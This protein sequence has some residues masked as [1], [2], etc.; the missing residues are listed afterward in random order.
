MQLILLHM[1]VRLKHT[2]QIICLVLFLLYAWPNLTFNIPNN[3]PL[4]LKDSEKK[5]CFRDS[6][7]FFNISHSSNRN[8]WGKGIST[9]FEYRVLTL[10]RGLSW[11]GE[12]AST[13]FF[14]T[15]FQFHLTRQF[16]DYSNGPNRTTSLKFPEWLRSDKSA[17]EFVRHAAVLSLI[18][19]LEGAYSVHV[20]RNCV[21]SKKQVSSVL[22]ATSGRKWTGG[23]DKP[24]PR[25][26]VAR[27][28][29]I[30]AKI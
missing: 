26:Y 5:A 23:L 16:L 24:T 9:T 4:S 29:K 15:T 6:L 2:V 7:R 19:S 13:P 17:A 14:P 8:F 11:G 21:Y 1:L 22:A 25:S 3:R 20:W 27:D 18:I 10:F 28:H 30:L 12:C